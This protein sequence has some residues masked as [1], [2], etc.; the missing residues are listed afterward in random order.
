M[1][2]SGASLAVQRLR[3]RTSTAGGTGSIPNPGTKIPRA[4][5]CGQNKKQKCTSKISFYLLYILKLHVRFY[6]FKK[7]PK[8]TGKWNSS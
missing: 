7:S 5:Q 2:T 1:Y 8:K 3:L 4:S 6:F